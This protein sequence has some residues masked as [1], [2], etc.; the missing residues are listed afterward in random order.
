MLWFR[1][2]N[3]LGQTPPVPK[4]ILSLHWEDNDDTAEAFDGAF[5]DALRSAAPG[6]VEFYS[7][8]LDATRFPGGQSQALAAITAANMQPQNPCRN[9]HT[10][11]AGLSI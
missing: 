3:A 6:P 4:R 9:S 8:Y 1:P 2:P 10:S 11:S 5:Q 7:E